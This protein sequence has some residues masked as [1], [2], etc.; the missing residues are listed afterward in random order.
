MEHAT[1]LV[2]PGHLQE[3]KNDLKSAYR[4]VVILPSH[5]QYA[6]LEW[7][8]SGSDYHTWFM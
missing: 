6:G 1:R 4:C 2:Q 3:K 7:R 5:H 8:F